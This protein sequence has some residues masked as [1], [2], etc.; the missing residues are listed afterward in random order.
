MKTSKDHV[1]VNASCNEK[2]NK[3]SSQFSHGYKFEIAPTFVAQ[4]EY[5][6]K[7]RVVLNYAKK[8]M[9]IGLYMDYAAIYKKMTGYAVLTIQNIEPR[10][11][12]TIQ[13][14]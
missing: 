11:P 6:F 14:W 10:S 4:L 7:T 3:F 12:Q 13:I 1:R 2:E 9:R 5:I 8:T